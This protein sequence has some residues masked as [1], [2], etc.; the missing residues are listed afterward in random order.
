MAIIRTYGDPI[1]RKKSEKIK[2]IDGGIK[3]LTEDMIKSVKAYRGMG[4]AAN[5]V[6]Q[7]KS[8][9][10]V[11]RSHLDLSDEIIVAINP[12]IVEVSGKQSQEE[13]CLSIPGTFEQVARPLQATIKA[14]DLNGKEFVI[15]GRGLL[16][17]VLLHELDHLE[18][19]LFIDHLSNIRRKLLSKKLKSIAE[20]RERIY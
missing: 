3:D 16:A 12:V 6:G 11:D 17:R 13:G 8:V 4:L 10:V 14:L 5:Q 2:N 1:L 18:G 7:A 20:K 19:I 15:E 9:F